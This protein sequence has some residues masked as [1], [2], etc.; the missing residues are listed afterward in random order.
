MRDIETIL[1]RFRGW[2]EDRHGYAR[3][4]KARTGGPVAALFCSY[5][6]EEILAAAG[7]LPVR[8]Y[9]GHAPQDVTERHL[10]GMFC[11]FCRD[12]LSQGLL[13]RYDYA[14][15]AVIAQSCLHLRQAF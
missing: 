12:A 6:P 10:F 5:V 9:G 2:F 7:V 11:P 13:G 4:W 15:G 1:A 8:V 14:E 3:A